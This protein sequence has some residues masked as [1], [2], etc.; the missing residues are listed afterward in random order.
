M[1]GSS[2]WFVWKQISAYL[3][4][5]SLADMIYGGSISLNFQTWIQSMYC[6]VAATLSGTSCQ[7]SVVS[8]AIISSARFCSVRSLQRNSSLQ[9]RKIMFISIF[10]W[11]I[12]P[13]IITMFYSLATIS[14]PSKTCFALN[15]INKSLYTRA[16]IFGMLSTIFFCFSISI[17]MY[18]KIY[19]YAEASSKALHKVNQ[20]K[21]RSKYYSS[22]LK[23]LML[24]LLPSMGCWVTC[25][26]LVLVHI[27]RQHSNAAESSLVIILSMNSVVNPLLYT[28]HPFFSNWTNAHL[29]TMA[30]I[31]LWALKISFALRVAV[32]HISN[33]WESKCNQ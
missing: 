18:F 30:I 21:T 15:L 23:K 11:I 33:N 31:S 13:L 16:F 19:Q 8:F 32:Y 14:K 7:M 9:T 3:L 10:S 6:K 4:L 26:V 24:L 29:L 1:H 25:L 12:W 22:V 20:C 2:L 5:T 17:I 27:D 28:I